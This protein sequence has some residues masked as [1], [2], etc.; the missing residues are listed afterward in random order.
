MAN[1]GAGADAADFD[2]DGFSN[3]FEYVAGLVPTDPAS[4]FKSRIEPVVG[5]AT[6]MKIMFSPI[7]AGRTYTVK[8]SPSLGAAAM[9]TNLTGGITS[10][11]GSER[12][13]TDT[14]TTGGAKFYR[15]EITKP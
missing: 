5:D 2:K 14:N 15:V 1:S 9:W 4:I 7:I 13:I 10:D 11:N 8:T 3:L 6:Q 12:T